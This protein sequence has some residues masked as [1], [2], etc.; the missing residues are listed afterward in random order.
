MWFCKLFFS[1]GRNISCLRDELNI[2]TPFCTKFCI[3]VFCKVIS[4]HNV[5]LQTVF[6]WGRIKCL[7][8]DVLNF[9]LQLNFLEKYF[10]I[11]LRKK[12]PAR[13]IVLNLHIVVKKDENNFTINGIVKKSA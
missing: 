7:L 2:S 5:V 13:K 3:K 8:R 10:P 4:A 9:F 1:L 11:T 6:S 12:I